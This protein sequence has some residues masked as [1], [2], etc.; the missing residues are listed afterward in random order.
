[1]KP[2]ALALVWSCL[3]GVAVGEPAGAVPLA[4]VRL[5]PV[6]R[7]AV[8]DPGPGAVRAASPS[9][10]NGV[11]LM[12]RYV[13]K[14]KT[15]VPL[16]RPEPTE[17]TGTF[18]LMGGGRFYGKDLGPARIEVGLWKNVDILVKDDKFKAERQSTRQRFDFVRLTW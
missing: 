2:L 10:A 14:E 9:A 12:D 15:A 7:Q 1:M 5:D 3:A 6:S 13:V 4:R 11:V 8:A 16:E 17:A 18:T